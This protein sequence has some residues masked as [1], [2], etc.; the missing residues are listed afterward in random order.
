[1]TIL[2]VSMTSCADS[3][4]VDVNLFFAPE[5]LFVLSVVQFVFN[6]VDVRLWHCRQRRREQRIRTVVSRLA[7][8]EGEGI[9]DVRTIC[10]ATGGDPRGGDKATTR[11]L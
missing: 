11:T 4:D 8:K 6:V 1:V 2:V 7:N 10:G 3:T 9:D 5:T